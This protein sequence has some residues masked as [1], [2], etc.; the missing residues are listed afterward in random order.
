MLT[1]RAAVREDALRG[2]DYAD[3]NEMTVG[4][5]AHPDR[6]PGSGSCSRR[7]SKATVRSL[8]TAS[9]ERCIKD[10]EDHHWAS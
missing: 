8:R 7:A 9:I 4:P 10:M 6:P 5:D 3:L 1:G 2:D